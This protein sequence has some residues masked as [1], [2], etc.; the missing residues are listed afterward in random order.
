MLIMIKYISVGIVLES[1]SISLF[2]IAAKLET[3]FNYKII[4]LLFYFISLVF[5]FIKVTFKTFRFRD[6]I[7]LSFVLSFGFIIAYSLLGFLFYPGLVKDLA[8]FSFDHLIR[9]SLF[10]AI[11]FVFHIGLVLI[12]YTVKKFL[13]TYC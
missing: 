9:V 4:V 5:F 2:I 6:I 12:A 1:I 13:K 8:P 7:F 10:F 11:I 3:S